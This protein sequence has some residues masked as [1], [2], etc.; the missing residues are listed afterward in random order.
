MTPGDQANPALTLTARY[1][2]P[3]LYRR[4]LLN[5]IHHSTTPRG[6]HNTCL[7][8][9]IVP[10]VTLTPSHPTHVNPHLDHRSILIPPAPTHP[11]RYTATDAL[12]AHQPRSPIK[13][14]FPPARQPYAQTPTANHSHSTDPPPAHRHTRTPPSATPHTST[15]LHT[16]HHPPRPPPRQTHPSPASPPCQPLDHPAE[17]ATGRGPPRHFPPDGN[18][19][20]RSVRTKSVAEAGPHRPLAPT[21][22]GRAPRRRQGRQAGRRMPGGK[23]GTLIAAVSD[24]LRPWMMVWPGPGRERGRLD[25]PRWPMGKWSAPWERATREAVGTACCRTPREAQEQSPAPP[26]R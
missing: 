10:I 4:Y 25:Q 23:S 11:D 12:D 7:I 9:F 21:S 17:L 1:T 2:L 13:S 3:P 15:T 20:S 18:P 6:A 5:L 26:S 8:P 22:L 16:P 19:G 24:T 14:S